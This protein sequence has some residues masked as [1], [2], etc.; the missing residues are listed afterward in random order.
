M[1]KIAIVGSGAIGMLYAAYL[2]ERH[3]V[4]L[5]TRRQNQAKQL[6][7]KGLTLTVS[8]TSRKVRI[9]AMPFST[10]LQQNDFE[11]VFIT[12]KQY[13][14]D[15]ILPTLH[16]LAPE[17]TLIF[18]QNGMNHLQNLS[19]LPARSIFVGTVSHGATRLDDTS[20]SH[21]GEGKTSLSVFKGE[22]DP[23]YSSINLFE[24]EFPFEYASNYNTLLLEKLVINSV[25]NPLT[26]LFKV[27]NGELVEN[28]HF[29]SIA[30][31]LYRELEV[32]FG[33]LSDLCS[34]EKIVTVCQNTYHNRSSM[35]AD[36]ENGRQTEIDA[37][38]GFV[39]LQAE[40]NKSTLH[41]IPLLVKSIQ[42]EELKR[43]K[44]I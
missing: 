33:D 7:E 5:F 25:I 43:G 31:D 4:T 26:A 16:D 34:M 30:Q 38:L 24:K 1:L 41:L 27:S 32:V 40:K 19:N 44:R 39:L 29:F 11:V 10:M 12:V 28:P 2:Q 3:S 23:V 37:I 35:L 13:Q 42:G 15:Q 6:N 14:L 22:K 18:L 20:V 8:D 17:T 21:R 36:L 9:T